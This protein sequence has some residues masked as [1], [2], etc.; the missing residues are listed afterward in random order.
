MGRMF[1]NKNKKWKKKVT[2]KKKTNRLR[3]GIIGQ[4]CKRWETG[5]EIAIPDDCKKDIN[6]S[7]MF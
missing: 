5:S 4:S 1:W 6:I 3:Q 7:F 2:L